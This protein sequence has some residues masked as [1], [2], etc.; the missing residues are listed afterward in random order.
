M[1]TAVSSTSCSLPGTKRNRGTANTRKSAAATNKMPVTVKA[2][3]SPGLT[4]MPK[5]ATLLLSC[6]TASRMSSLMGSPSPPSFVRMAP[7]ANTAT[8]AIATHSTAIRLFL[9]K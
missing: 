2:E 1:P 8:S 6:N 5:K 3:I 7:T 4:S 9:L